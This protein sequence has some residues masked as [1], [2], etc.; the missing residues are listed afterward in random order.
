MGK[1]VSIA[2]KC[3]FSHRTIAPRHVD[4]VPA[5][6]VADKRDLHG[7]AP[8]SR[9]DADLLP[10]SAGCGT[11]LC[12][13]SVRTS[14]DFLCQRKERDQCLEEPFSDDHDWGL[15]EVN[16]VGPGK[17][18]IVDFR[19][20]VRSRDAIWLADALTGTGDSH[21]VEYPTNRVGAGLKSVTEP[22]REATND[23]DALRVDV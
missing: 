4:V 22:C 19:I 5:A 9:W 1:V 8:V 23:N 11:F 20:A 21:F 14:C 6:S 13:H 12:S 16:A 7:H 15:F 3:P 18:A 10:Q 2:G 17:D